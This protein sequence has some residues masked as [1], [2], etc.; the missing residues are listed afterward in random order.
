MNHRRCVFRDNP[1]PNEPE[2][3]EKIMGVIQ[4]LA[5]DGLVLELMSDET[6]NVTK[7]HQ[8]TWQSTSICR[9]SR[10]SRYC[11]PGR[12]C[13]NGGISGEPSWV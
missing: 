9:F 4:A 3:F 8:M 1:D 12:S 11:Y 2:F 6:S 7:L 5:Q 13:T 10:V